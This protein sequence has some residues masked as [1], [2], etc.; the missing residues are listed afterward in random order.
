MITEQQYRRLMKNLRTNNGNVT[1]AAA[2]AG[3]HRQTA[4]KYLRLE[5]DP[6][7]SQRPLQGVPGAGTTHY[8]TAF[9]MR[10]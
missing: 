2:K 7:R 1:L 8:Q 10:H 4:V 9:G 5:R 6:R 3:M